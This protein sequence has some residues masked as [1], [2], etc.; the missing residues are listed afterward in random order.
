MA[1]SD[2]CGCTFTEIHTIL[3]SRLVSI[4]HNLRFAEIVSSSVRFEAA[5]RKP[6][7]SVGQYLE[8]R[9]NI[10]IHSTKGRTQEGEP[11]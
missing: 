4:P 6:R 5:Q 3:V 10:K 1:A 2:L 9:R 7:E 8:F 11:V